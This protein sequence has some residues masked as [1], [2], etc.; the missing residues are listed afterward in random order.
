MSSH[1]VPYRSRGVARLCE[2]AARRAC[3]SYCFFCVT[4]LVVIFFYLLPTFFIFSDTVL[5][6]IALAAPT[7]LETLRTVRGMDLERLKD[8]W[9]RQI[10]RG[11]PAVEPV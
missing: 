11:F 7:N 6:S 8:G 4:V 9:R 10:L 1:A 2:P 5:R 3:S